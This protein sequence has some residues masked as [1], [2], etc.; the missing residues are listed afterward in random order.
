MAPMESS[1]SLIKKF[2]P[3]I[4]KSIQGETFK[5]LHVFRNQLNWRLTGFILWFYRFPYIKCCKL[6]ELKQDEPWK[7]CLMPFP[8]LFP[9]PSLRCCYSVKQTVMSFTIFL[10]TW[11]EMSRPISLHQLFTTLYTVFL[12]LI[13]GPPLNLWH[14][15]TSPFFRIKWNHPLFILLFY[16][17]CFIQVLTL[18]APVL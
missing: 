15:M 17:P 13:L 11:L 7:S 12:P 4:N 6:L 18:L 14:Y 16:L 9:L 10:L 8:L 5:R 2:C 3:W 1:L